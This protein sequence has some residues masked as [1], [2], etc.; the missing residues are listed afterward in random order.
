[1]SMLERKWRRGRNDAASWIADSDQRL[2]KRGALPEW[3]DPASPLQVWMDPI[4]YAQVVAIF[5]AIRPREVVE[6]GSGGSTRALL[7]RAGY[8][9]R[10]ITVEHDEAWSTKVREAIADPRLEVRHVA[11]AEEEPPPADGDAERHAALLAWRARAEH[12][13]SLFADYLDEPRR[14][15]AKPQ[16]VLV[17]GRARCFCIREGFEL[18]TPGGVLILHDAHRPE[19]RDAMMAIGGT[20]L[21]PW[22]QG[23]VAMATKPR[24]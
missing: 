16:V 21:E 4:E 19:Y 9:Q 22:N 7:S 20:F 15:G 12:D 14:L 24:N 11:S 6:W 3:H 1:M 18:L 2:V 23:Q 8:V 13:R 17:D 10:W 5:E